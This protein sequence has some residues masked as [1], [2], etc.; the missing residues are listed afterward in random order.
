QLCERFVTPELDVSSIPQCSEMSIKLSAN[1]K[2]QVLKIAVVGGSNDQ[3][4][5]WLQDDP[6]IPDEVPRKID[7][8]KYFGG[9]NCIVLQQTCIHSL[10]MK[11]MAQSC[12]LQA[13]QAA[14]APQTKRGFPT[15][16]L[17]STIRSARFSLCLCASVSLCLG[18][19]STSAAATHSS[20][21]H[22][23]TL[24]SA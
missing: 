18:R 10:Y 19:S 20:K 6:S 24:L 8:F 5:T 15:M 14:P 13:R 21:T 9:Y 2:S 17:L 4:A 22:Y 1:R 11:S 3:D 23:Q 12:C 16:S 7:V